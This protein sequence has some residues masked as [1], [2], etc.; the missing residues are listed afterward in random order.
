MRI[1]IKY[2]RGFAGTGLGTTLK[3]LVNQHAGAGSNW[4]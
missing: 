3:Y 4:A 1:S 2:L